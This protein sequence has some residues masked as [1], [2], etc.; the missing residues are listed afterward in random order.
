MQCAENE[1]P[2]QAGVNGDARSLQVANFTD[3]DDVRRL[4]Q[5]RAQRGRKRHPDFSIHLHLVDPVHLILYRLLDRDDLAVR[6]VDVIQA[7]V[8]R[9]CFSG[10]RRPCDEKNAVGQLDQALERFLVVAEKSELRQTEHKAG[11]VE[12]AHDHTLTVISRNRRDTQIDR[13]L[14]DLHLNPPV[15]WQSLFRDAHRARHN[16]NATDDGRLQTLRWRLHFLEDAVDS[17]TDTKFLIER[18]EMNVARTCAVGLDQQHRHHP[19]DRRVRLIA[20]GDLNAFADLQAKIDIL[21]DFLLQEVGGLVGRAV[22]FN[23]RLAN[24]LR[25]AANQFNFALKQKTKAVDRVDVERIAHG[26]N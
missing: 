23:Q 13:L 17:E 14:S 20:L 16:F 2:S 11:F 8:E 3:H 9:A 21:P 4:A 5:D 26:D 19:N 22:I 25:A 24:F 7:G 1:V 15:L 6:L 10:A 12:H 18:L